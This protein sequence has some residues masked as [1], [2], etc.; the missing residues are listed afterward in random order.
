MINFY[1]HEYDAPLNLQYI[2]PHISQKLGTMPGLSHDRAAVSVVSSVSSSRWFVRSN[3][4]RALRLHLFYPEVPRFS[5]LAV[6][7]R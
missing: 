4:L 1:F 7:P 3:L 2:Y 6:Y 5:R